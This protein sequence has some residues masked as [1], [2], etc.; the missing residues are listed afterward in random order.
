MRRC[1]ISFHCC[2]LFSCALPQ[3]DHR[4]SGFDGDWQAL[5]RGT[6]SVQLVKELRFDCAPFSETFFLRVRDGVVSGYMQADENYSF[7]AAIDSTGSFS[8]R[9]PTDSVYT[10]KEAQVKRKSSIVLVLQGSLSARD[11]SGEFV[12]GD[13]A[14]DDQGCRTDVQFVSV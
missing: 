8:A 13:T 14:L 7:V 5:M 9:M 11:S 6:D 10:Y 12:V 2:V 3:D 4:L 1:V